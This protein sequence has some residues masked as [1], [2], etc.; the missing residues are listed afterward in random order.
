MGQ[1]NSSVG[2]VVFIGPFPIAFGSGPG[3][4]YL[5]LASVVIG[6]IMVI[7]LLLWGWRLAR[8]REG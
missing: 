7:L 4:G 2:G 6:G 5:A 3:G 1:G 8:T